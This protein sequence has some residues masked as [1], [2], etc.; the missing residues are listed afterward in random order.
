MRFNVS[1]RP[2]PVFDDSEKYRTIPSVKSTAQ[3]GLSALDE[4]RV[5]HPDLEIER[6]PS[7]TPTLNRDDLNT[8]EVD[9][10]TAR[11]SGQFND[12]N[13]FYV[14]VINGYDKIREHLKL[15]VSN[16]Q[17]ANYRLDYVLQESI[18]EDWEKAGF[19]T[20]WVIE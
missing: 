3:I 20:E 19:P 11:R 5:D 8:I 13:T 4:I 6:L 15:E 2:E 17:C 14:S 10:E 16:L 12:C 18:I 1:F 9:E 7:T